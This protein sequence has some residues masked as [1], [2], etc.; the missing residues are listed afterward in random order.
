MWAN[1]GAMIGFSIRDHDYVAYAPTGAAWSVNG[2]TITSTLA[3]KSYFTVAV[4]PTKAA[5]TDST[6]IA[7]ADLVRPLR[8]RAR[9]RHPG[10]LRLQ[11]GQRQRVDHVRLHHRRRREG[12][13]NKTVVSLYPHQWKALAG[14]HARSSQTYVSPRGAM[15][16]LVGVERL[17]HLDDVP[18]HPA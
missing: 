5:D 12:T 10:V 2:T 3:G 15:K 6:R 1:S 18:R 14:A 11:P 4:L 13:E 7:L 17:R 16:N 9:D 8:P